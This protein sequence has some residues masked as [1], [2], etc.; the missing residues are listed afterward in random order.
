[1]QI[2]FDL[3]DDLDVTLDPDNYQDATDPAPPPAGN[4]K[5]AIEKWALRK[6]RDGELVL[7]R[8]SAGKPTFP[9]ITI[10]MVRIVEPFPFNDRKVALYQDFK[11]K[12]TQRMGETVNALAD[13]TRA[14]DQT[15]GFNGLAAG[16]KLFGELAQ[17]GT[18][19]AYCDWVWYDGDYV[20]AAMEEQFD[21]RN[22]GELSEDEKKIAGEIYNKAKFRGMKKNRLPN[23]KFS[24]IWKNPASGNNVT[25]KLQIVKFYPSLSSVKYHVIEG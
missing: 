6:T 21:G 25:A 22:Y 12:P 1:M 13:L 19:S 9:K 5:L 11:T 20:T 7:D 18:L 14:L 17:N 24:H 8:N 15:Q 4:Y 16:I 2:D 3:K 23:G 10:E